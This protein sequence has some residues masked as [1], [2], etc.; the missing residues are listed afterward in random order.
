MRSD[1]ASCNREPE[2]RE[3]VAGSSKRQGEIIS[4]VKAPPP[5][6]KVDPY[7]DPAFN[8]PAVVA[9]IPRNAG[10]KAGAIST[11]APTTK[12]FGRM[13]HLVKKLLK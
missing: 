12:L 11:H 1:I 3:L 4:T 10:Q 9:G 6:T 2:Y 8:Q 7:Q 13:L 5:E